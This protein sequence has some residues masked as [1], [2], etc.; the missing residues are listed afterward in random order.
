[1]S[2]DIPT[3]GCEEI[4]IVPYSENWP[5][6]FAME[7]KRLQD[8][9]GNT[10]V[11]IEHIGSTA[12]PGLAAKPVIDIIAGVRSMQ[13]ADG[14]IRELKNLGYLYPE[15]FNASLPDRRFFMHM[16]KKKTE[17][18]HHLHLISYQGKEWKEAIAFR[19]LLRGS[20]AVAEKY[21]ALK[22][23][24]SLK[25]KNDREGYTSAK[26]AFIE[27]ALEPKQTKSWLASEQDVEEWTLN[28]KRL[29]K[30][31]KKLAAALLKKNAS[32]R[33]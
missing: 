8:A 6:S 11:A 25:Y 33:A 13:E 26:T 24:L 2:P 30:K 23:T 4:I 3:I 12:V 10:I 29:M 20:H 7:K 15:E 5:A 9:I 22:K 1:M 17:R 19:N 31:S 18:T 14:L 27:R 32:G 16:N 28:D 21:A